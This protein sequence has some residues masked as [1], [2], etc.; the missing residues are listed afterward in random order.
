MKTP[1]KRKRPRAKKVIRF[2]SPNAKPLLDLAE[3]HLLQKAV[4]AAT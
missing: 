3:E 4:Q 2:T 1:Q